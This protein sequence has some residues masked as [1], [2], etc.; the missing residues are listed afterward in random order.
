MNPPDIT[1]D[2]TSDPVVWGP[3]LTVPNAI[4]FGRLLCV[5]LFVW[6]L[7]GVDDRLAAAILLAVLG[8]TDWIDGYIA[9]RFDQGSELGKLLDPTADRVMLIVAVIAIAADGS[10]PLWFAGLT[11]ARELLVAAAALLLGALGVRHFEVSWW[12]KTGTFLLMV[13][14][15]FF[16]A[17]HADIWWADT[18]RVLAWLCGIPGLVYSLV[19]AAGYIAPSL[20]AVRARRRIG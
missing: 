14:Y 4:S 13:S 2:G 8:A 1:E 10:V 5:P 20:E 15:P 16:L 18:A 11:L 3:V 19:S 17:S 12:G 7:F 9:R 6:L